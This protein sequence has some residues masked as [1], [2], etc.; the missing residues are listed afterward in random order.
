MKSFV[1]AIVLTFC[2][3]SFTDASAERSPELN[4]DL[5]IVHEALLNGAQAA[6]N[7]SCKSLETRSFCLTNAC[8]HKE[9]RVCHSNT[10]NTPALKIKTIMRED[11]NRVKRIRFVAKGEFSRLDTWNRLEYFRGETLTKTAQK[12]FAS[13]NYSCS[14]PMTTVSCESPYRQGNPRRRYSQ[15]LARRIECVQVIKSECTKPSQKYAIQLQSVIDAYALR[16][17]N[18]A[19]L[20]NKTLS[21]LVFKKTKAQQE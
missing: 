5:K 6:Y 4:A 7:I 13:L 17:E 10:L 3:I 21:N 18:Y 8:L 16:S 20:N 11:G 19:I 9:V 12:L 1:T 15:R 2:F 14:K